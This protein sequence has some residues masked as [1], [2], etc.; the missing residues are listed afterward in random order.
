[1]VKIPPVD[2]FRGCLLSCRILFDLGRNIGLWRHAI[3]SA[4]VCADPGSGHEHNIA[5]V[6]R[7]VDQRSGWIFPPFIY[8]RHADPCG[9]E[10]SFGG[11]VFAGVLLDGWLRLWMAGIAN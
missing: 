4:V 2:Q 1:M 5:A 9:R 7:P 6:V 8:D 3:W 11:R 10:C